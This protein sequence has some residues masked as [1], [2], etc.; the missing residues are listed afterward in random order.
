MVAPCLMALLV[1]LQF[2]MACESPPF[3]Q[4]EPVETEEREAVT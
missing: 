1:E 4:A 3:F 2:Y